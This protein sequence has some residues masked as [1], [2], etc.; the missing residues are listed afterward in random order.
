[1][2][3][4]GR[5]FT[6][7][8]QRIIK[9]LL[10]LTLR[11]YGDAWNPVLPL[12]FDF[13]RA[14]MHGKLA[15][16]VGSN[17]VVVT[18]TL[19]IE[20]GPVGGFLHICI[21]YSMLEPVRDLLSSPIQHEI[22]IDCRWVTQMAQQMNNADLELSVEFVSIPSTVG[23]VLKLQEGDVLPIDLP[24]TVTAMVDRTPVIECGYGTSNGHYALRVEQLI[25]HNQEGKSD[26]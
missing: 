15:N 13:V 10:D 22:E 17:E 7:T 3:I 5:E 2:R 4:E 19:H 11:C 8:E 6:R 18:T 24:A 26:E 14:E 20:F 25:H 23:D 12:E 16:I 1:M 9:R 21:P